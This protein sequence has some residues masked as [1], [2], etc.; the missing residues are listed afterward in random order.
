MTLL[1]SWIRYGLGVLCAS[2]EQSREILNGFT[3]YPASTLAFVIRFGRTEAQSS[4]GL[5]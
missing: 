1:R 3:F 2:R 4:A 5:N